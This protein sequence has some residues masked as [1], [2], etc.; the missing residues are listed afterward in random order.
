VYTV[1]F[2]YLGAAL[3]LVLLVAMSD[4][5]LLDSLTSGEIAEE[6]VR[7][8]VGSI[9]L[10]LAIPLTTAIAATLVPPPAAGAAPAIPAA[11]ASPPAP[12]ETRAEA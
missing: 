10:V 1:A 5:T 9:G 3:P 12:A 4:R 2:A 11:A 7:T 6:V 8:L